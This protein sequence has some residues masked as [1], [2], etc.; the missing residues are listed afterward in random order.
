MF[1]KVM[2]RNGTISLKEIISKKVICERI[3]ALIYFKRFQQ[4]VNRCLLARQ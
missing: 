4:N 2:N 1:L 3:F